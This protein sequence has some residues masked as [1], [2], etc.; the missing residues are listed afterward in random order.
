[1]PS[2]V[3]LPNNVVPLRP[4]QMHA[5]DSLALTKPVGTKK[6]R[7]MIAFPTR[8]F[9]D[10][11]AFLTIMA[12]LQ[13]TQTADVVFQPLVGGNV[14]RQRNFLARTAKKY[15]FDYLFFVDSDVILPSDVIDRL[16]AHK[17]DIIGATY[18]RRVPPH[19]LLGC[20]API[21]AREGDTDTIMNMVQLP[22]G[23][24]MIRTEALDN[25]PQ[26]WFTYEYPDE[27]T[28]ISEDYAFCAKALKAGLQIFWDHSIQVGHLTKRIL[29]NDERLAPKIPDMSKAQAAEVVTEDTHG[30]GSGI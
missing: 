23:A 10:M 2:A 20:R 8:D 22:T 30:G 29:W 27:T 19:D 9:V 16:L 14:P 13:N 26:P 12:V 6:P 25:I 11:Q 1:M 28:E 4:D 21:D 24:L 5:D 3:S 15:G 18:R 17:K 7:V